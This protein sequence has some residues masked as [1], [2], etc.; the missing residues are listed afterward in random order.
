LLL[1]AGLAL[2]GDTYLLKSNGELFVPNN[3]NG[4][5]VPFYILKLFADSF[6]YTL[7]SRK[8][9]EILL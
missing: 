7:Y 8:V 4:L 3:S 2:K 9:A 6:P 5:R 1:R